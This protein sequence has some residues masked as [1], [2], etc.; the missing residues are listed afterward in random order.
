MK[1]GKRDFAAKSRTREGENL[2][3]DEEEIGH[4]RTD[5]FSQLFSRQHL[6]HLTQI[7]Q[8]NIP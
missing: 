1:E 4:E 5:P 6:S 2:A 8:I 3:A 7:S